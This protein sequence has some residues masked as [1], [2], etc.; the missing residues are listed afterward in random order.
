[1][2]HA[3]STLA[4]EEEVERGAANATPEE[5]AVKTMTG[6]PSV[7]RWIGNFIGH[8]TAGFLTTIAVV[9]GLLVLLNLLIGCT[10]PPTGYRSDRSVNTIYP[11]SGTFAH[12][13]Q[14]VNYDAA[15]KILRDK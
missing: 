7:V 10:T 9:A 12:R 11:P 5:S 1:M 2:V 14:T 6:S 3:N 8:M 15:R 4:E 13:Q